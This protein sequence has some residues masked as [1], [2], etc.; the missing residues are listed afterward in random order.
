MRPR[1]S[2]VPAGV[3]AVLGAA[4]ALGLGHSGWSLVASFRSA[5][6]IV[7]GCAPAR[8]PGSRRSAPAEPGRRARPRPTAAC[9]AIAS[10]TAASGVAPVVLDV[11]RDLGATAR[12]R[13]TPRS[14]GPPAS[15]SGPPSRISAAIA[16]ASS[17]VAGDASSTLN[18]TSGGR[19][20]DEHRARGRVQPRRPE[21][22]A[23]AR[24]RSIRA[25]SSSGP[26]RRSSAR[27]RPPASPPYRNTGKPSSSPSRSPSTS[28]SAKAA[29]RSASSRYTIG[30]TS[31][32]PT[33]G[34]DPVVAGEVD[35]ADRLAAPRSSTAAR[36]PRLAGEREHAALVV[37][38]AV[39]VQQPPTRRT[40]RR[41]RRSRP[42][43]GPRRRSGPPAACYAV[44]LRSTYRPR[45]EHRAA[46]DLERR[47][48]HD[49]VEVDRHRDV[50]TD[51]CAGPERDMDRA[52]DL[53]VLEHVARSAARGRW[54]PPRAR[55]G[56]CPSRRGPRAGP[57][58][59]G[60]SPPSAPT[61]R[62]LA[63]GQRSRAAPS[64]PSGA[65][66]EATIRPSPPSGAMNASPHGR[67]PNAPGL[68]EV[69]VV[70]DPLPG[71]RDSS[72]KSR[73]AR[74]GDTRL[75]RPR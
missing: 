11:R 69:A 8:S 40:P 51:P 10:T 26:P 30:A 58:Y 14:P 19:A 68:G 64:D 53:L 16:F 52:E 65:R 59:S 33:R 24:R 67:F 54:S 28:A 5:S 35:P 23:S 41:S 60:P 25:A 74:A 20:A 18:A 6:S 75:A 38:V 56:S 61:I 17:S 42:G 73:A 12:C 47:V 3:P 21:V 43:R 72:V 4:L 2:I 9:R 62:P 32:A 27:V 36:A 57:R 44:K 39:D 71:R 1:A 46:V 29:P 13:A 48:Q 49:D 55:P 70:G 31:M 45:V 37:R 15:P 22:R 50:A 63:H 34:C 66:L 7:R